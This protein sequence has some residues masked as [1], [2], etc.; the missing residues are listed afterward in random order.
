[1]ADLRDPNTSG[2]LIRTLAFFRKDVVEVLRQ[3]RLIF[4]LVLGPFLILLLFGF[5]FRPAPP[6]LRTVLVVPEGSGLAERSQELAE[7]MGARVSLVATEANEEAGKALLASGD[8]D[9]M[10]VIPGDA[11]ETVRGNQRAVISVRHDQIDP[12]ESSFI[13]LFA[14]SAV[15]QV[16]RRVLRELVQVG[17]ERAAAAEAA[18]ATAK[19]AVTAMS[20]ALEAGDSQ[21]A[22]ASRNE[23]VRALDQIAAEIEPSLTVMRGLETE[24][25]TGTSQG[26]DA[27]A[28]AREKADDL[29]QPGEETQGLLL[30]VE[31]DLNVLETQLNE[32]RAIDPAVLVSPFSEETSNFQGIEIPFSNYY[33]PGVVSL[34]AQHLA[35]TF[36]AL[37][38]VRERTLGTIELFRVSPVSGGEALIGKYLASLTIG[39]LVVGALT[40]A[41][42]AFFDFQLAGS[43]G[44][45]AIS[46]VLVLLA[47][48]GLG[49]VL[50]AAADNESQA[51]QYA[52]IALLVSIFFSGFFISVER[53]I[54]PVRALSFLIPASYGIVALQDIAFR[55]TVPSG[56]TIGGA[57]LLAIVLLYS[58]WQLLRRRV[59]VAR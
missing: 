8:A 55:G 3:P 50:A 13:E 53:L 43:W 29:A 42:V 11:L 54:P 4:T 58:A 17:Q 25:G 40:A 2:R 49:F 39:A 33:V 30:A 45:Y 51:V 41:A 59:V 32:F 10:V 57:A 56:P 18:L 44:W 5:G 9:V 34:L 26:T 38:L 23:L 47:A 52:M 20:R 1:M 21:A 12:F 31:D 24:V 7:T 19:A 22:E 46:T 6:A 27:L 36:A 15:E 16:N 35:I 28:A 48:Q 37:S 14:Q